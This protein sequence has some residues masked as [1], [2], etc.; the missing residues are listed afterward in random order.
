MKL[1]ILAIIIIG[2]LL[3][4]APLSIGKPDAVNGTPSNTGVQLSGIPN[5][6]SSLIL[7]LVPGELIVKFKDEINIHI[8]AS[9]RET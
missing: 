6:A 3:S 9:P 1:K 5:D 8:S 2:M 7:E 4:A